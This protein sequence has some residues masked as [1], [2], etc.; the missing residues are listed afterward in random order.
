MNDAFSTLL[1]S[2]PPMELSSDEGEALWLRAKEHGKND[3]F[4]RDTVDLAERWAR[5]I[6]ND[7]LPPKGRFPRFMLSVRTVLGWST[8]RSFSDVDV[9]ELLEKVDEYGLYA[10]AYRFEMVVRLLGTSWKYGPELLRQ[11]EATNFRRPS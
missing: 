9:W 7:L 4:L 5:M 1:S 6:Q 2:L 10:N 11:C 3:I 8:A